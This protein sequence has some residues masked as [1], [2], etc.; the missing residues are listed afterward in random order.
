MTE[1][2]QSL[3]VSVPSVMI[4]EGMTMSYN[5]LTLQ[6]LLRSFSSCISYELRVILTEEETEILSSEE[7]CL[8]SEDMNGSDKILFL[9]PGGF[10]TVKLFG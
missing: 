10:S 8:R 5:D 2:Q 1:T 7:A 3:S 6:S 9:F 4:N